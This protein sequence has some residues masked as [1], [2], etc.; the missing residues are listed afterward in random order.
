[1]YRIVFLLII[2]FNSSTI[3]L[4]QSKTVHGKV[5]AFKNLALQNIKVVSK[6]SKLSVLTDSLGNYTI[7]CKSKDRLIFLG[8]GFEKVIKRVNNKD[9]INI[10]MVLKEDDKSIAEAKEFG[11][12]SESNLSYSLA[13][14]AEYNNDFSNYPDIFAML[15]GK[16]PGIQI[17]NSPLGRKIQI[18]GKNSI[19]GSSDALYVI[20]GVISQSIENIEPFNV[21]TIKILKNAAIY[22][23]RGGSGAIV[24]TTRIK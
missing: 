19:T 14:Y 12:V 9:T 24:I 1:M 5:Y 6:K 7:N 18:R 11:H 23:A 3:C 17:I 21:K 4:S 20:D 22:G 16:F 2:L 15:Q 8:A 10:K 13:N